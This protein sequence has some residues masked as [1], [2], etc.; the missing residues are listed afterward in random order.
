[1]GLGRPRPG[2]RG[3]TRR[4][5]TGKTAL[6]RSTTDDLLVVFVVFHLREAPDEVVGR[7]AALDGDLA[8]VV[9][10]VDIHGVVVIGVYVLVFLLALVVRSKS[11]V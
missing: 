11:H 8:V 4:R 9:V 6:P 2:K 1:M 10:F 5:S 7:R 3:V